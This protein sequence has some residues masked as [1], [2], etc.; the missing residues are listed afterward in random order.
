MP[1]DGRVVAHE[2]G[3]L[4]VTAAAIS[5]A[6]ANGPIIRRACH[7]S[8]AGAPTLRS[9]AVSRRVIQM[10]SRMAL[11]AIIGPPGL[12]RGRL[13]NVWAAFKEA[14]RTLLTRSSAGGMFRAYADAAA[15][16]IMRS[17]W[18]SSSIARC[19]SGRRDPITAETTG[20]VAVL[21][22]GPARRLVRVD[23]AH[24]ADARPAMVAGSTRRPCSCSRRT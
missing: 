21:V 13:R 17:S 23:L 14:V 12:P 7:G 16:P 9:D 18:A 19:T 6:A 20:I 15:S 24:S 1:R 3:G 22:M 8:T 5:A 11:V 4:L 2:E 10:A